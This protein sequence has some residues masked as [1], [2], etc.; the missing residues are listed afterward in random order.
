MLLGVLCAG[1]RSRGCQL[2]C[3]VPLLYHPVACCGLFHI[4]FCMHVV[5]ALVFAQVWAAGW[6]PG[7]L[8]VGAVVVVGLTA[9][10]FPALSVLACLVF[11]AS[12]LQ[13]TPS[14]VPT[15]R[16]FWLS[17]GLPAAH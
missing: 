4:T 10:V 12:P 7:F 17:G 3:L 6:P 8:G 2:V 13:P 16:R 1:V 14:S 9:E 15:G 11:L 5:G